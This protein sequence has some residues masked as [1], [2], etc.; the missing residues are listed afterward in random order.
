MRE[1]NEAAFR[2]VRREASQY[3]RQPEAHRGVAPQVGVPGGQRPLNGAE[4]LLKPVLP[5]LQIRK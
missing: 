4:P 5:A 2:A 1:K 3:L